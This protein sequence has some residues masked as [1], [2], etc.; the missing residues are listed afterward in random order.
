MSQD[1]QTSS[2]PSS[3]R[4]ISVP[5]RRE[6]ERRREGER[7]REEERSS[8]ARNHRKARSPFEGLSNS[9]KTPGH[10]SDIFSPFFTE[11]FLPKSVPTNYDPNINYPSNINHDSKINPTNYSQS[12]SQLNQ[13]QFEEKEEKKNVSTEVLLQTS[14]DYNQNNNYSLTAG[15]NYSL[16]AGANYHQSRPV[17]STGHHYRS[18]LSTSPFGHVTF[19]SGQLNLARSAHGSAAVQ[20]AH[21]S[22]HRSPGQKKSVSCS[23]FQSNEM[24]FI[25]SYEETQPAGAT[26]SSAENIAG[27]SGGFSSGANFSQNVENCEKPKIKFRKTEY[28]AKFRPFST[29][30]YVS[31]NGFKKPKHLDQVTEVSRAKDWIYEVVERSQ[32]ALEFQRR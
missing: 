9:S 28:K 16:T 8:S 23:N 17:S 27:G 2:S 19:S 1:H 24:N 11:T 6:E 22:A 25:P 29:Y 4:P 13:Q 26:A 30:V 21:G 3:S 5:R 14:S 20:S 32:K 31:G 12:S 15:S 10:I 18:Y 7:G